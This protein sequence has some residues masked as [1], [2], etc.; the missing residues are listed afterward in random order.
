MLAPS[1]PEMVVLH[2]VTRFHVLG[3]SRWVVLLALVGSNAFAKKYY[4]ATNGSDSN[5]GTEANPWLTPH[6]AR[7][8]LK[9]GDT[10]YFR[11]GTYPINN[12]VYLNKNAGTASAPITY[13]SYPGETATFAFS[14]VVDPPLQTSMIFYVARGYHRFERLHL[15]Q[16]AESRAALTKIPRASYG[17]SVWAPGVEIRDCEIHH[18]TGSG[19]FASDSA[20]N[21]LVERNHIHHIDPLVYSGVAAPHGVY[22]YGQNVIIRKNTIHDLFYFCIKMA[23]DF[24]G[25]VYENFCYKA[26]EGITSQNGPGLQMS[27]DVYNNVITHIEFHASNAQGPG[28]NI[29]NGGGV[30][31][32]NNTIAFSNFGASLRNTAQMPILK[33]NIFYENKTQIVTSR[34]ALQMD[35][36]LYFSSTGNKFVSQVSGASFSGDLVEWR[37]RDG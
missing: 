34:P 32:F 35:N 37:R 15:T 9:A 24:T 21:L 8:T 16:T 26:G 10:V 19:V 4:V 7:D 29:F 5:P 31:V 3:F 11:Q 13:A 6:K 28:I 30:R 27:A 18:L 2:Q 12:F 20:D 22:A 25:K 17:F 1:H 33:N 36:N 23:G 14:S